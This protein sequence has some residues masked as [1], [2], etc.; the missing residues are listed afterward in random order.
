ME[1]LLE[2]IGGLVVGTI[3]FAI[4]ERDRIR[5]WRARYAATRARANAA[6]SNRA[7]ADALAATGFFEDLSP[8]ETRALRDEIEKIGYGGVFSHPWRVLG[9]D[10]EELADGGVGLHLGLWAPSFERLGIVPLAGEDRFLEG[11]VHVLEM[12]RETLVLETAED[13]RLQADEPG[14]YRGLSWAV[15]PARLFD[16]INRDLAATG[17]AERVY[18]VYG[19]NDHTGLLLTEP[20]RAAIVSS[21]GIRRDE[22]PYVRTL[23][24]PFGGMDPSPERT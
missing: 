13:V 10:D 20:M 2:T 11:G 9:A 8:A 15:V 12:P 19:G 23:D 5:G 18:S 7:L 24:W 17:R 1:K 6:R 21:P 22:L 3:L 16:R 14:R 4:F